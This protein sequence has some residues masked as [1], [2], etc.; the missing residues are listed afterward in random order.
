MD[1]EVALVLSGGGARGM[2]HIGVLK[3]LNDHGIFPKEIAG[4]S[5]GAVIGLLYAAG[6]SP[7]EIIK[8][9]EQ[10]KFYELFTSY[11]KIRKRSLNVLYPIIKKAIG[12]DRFD[13][14]KIPLHIAVSN[15]NT[16]RPEIISDGDCIHAALA[17]ASI[18][19]IFRAYNNNKMDY[20]DGG[21]LNNFPIDPFLEKEYAIIGCDVNYLG[22][23]KEIKKILHFVERTFRMA[24]F[25]N[26]RIR[27]R[28]CDFLIEPEKTSDYSTFDFKHAR[29]LYE[30]GEDKTLFDMEKIKKAISDSTDMRLDKKSLLD[31]L[32]MDKISEKRTF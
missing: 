6:L 9:V 4:T 31:V 3:A 17:S 32:L 27:E 25:Q 7:N 29:F 28:Y 18:P 8:Q 5:I 10:L 26:V 11:T 15:V 20:I 16:S 30:L 1:R 22:E 24:L 21:L 23:E 19:F 2:A 12:V 14:L 13:Q